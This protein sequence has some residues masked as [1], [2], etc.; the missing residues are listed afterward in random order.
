MFKMNVIKQAQ[1][2]DNLKKVIGDKYDTVANRK[3]YLD[4]NCHLE[5]LRSDLKS[6]SGVLVVKNNIG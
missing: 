6:D 5:E 3:Q 1:Y 4:F 2:L